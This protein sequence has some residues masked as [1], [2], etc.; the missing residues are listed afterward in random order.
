M[1]RAEAS[2]AASEERYRERW[3]WDKERLETKVDDVLV[4]IGGE[5]EVQALPD[6]RAG[7][8]R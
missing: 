8:C 6:D 4:L 7:P 1:A 3:R 2:E 5:E